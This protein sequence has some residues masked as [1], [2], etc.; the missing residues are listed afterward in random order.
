MV[1]VLDVCGSTAKE[2]ETREEIMQE[3]SCRMARHD[4]S[5]VSTW[6]DWFSIPVGIF[7][8][9]VITL[10]SPPSQQVFILIMF[11]IVFF[12]YSIPLL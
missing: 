8:M 10:H 7:N 9:H 5:P 1:T 4:V 2:P 6:K 12:M 11:H 3:S